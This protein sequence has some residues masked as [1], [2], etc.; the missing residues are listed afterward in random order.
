MA[1][2][3]AGVVYTCSFRPAK[4]LYNGTKC[5]SW[6]DETSVSP[7]PSGATDG[8]EGYA[9]KPD[10]T[11]VM[12]G[13]QNSDGNVYEHQDDV[14]KGSW[15]TFPLPGARINRPLDLAYDGNNYAY[16]EN[17]NV[18]WKSTA[19][20]SNNMVQLGTFTPTMGGTNEISGM[21]FDDKGYIYYSNS[22]LTNTY[23]YRASMDTPVD[24]VLYA[25]LDI[26]VKDLASCAYPTAFTG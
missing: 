14:S 3:T 12:I 26:V 21:A 1:I 10:G 18:I 17:L 8:C 15:V 11:Y 4:S 24:A 25:T 9:T 22:D 5:D 23:I 20:N 13:Y 6:S 7:W 16:L 2:D 19:P